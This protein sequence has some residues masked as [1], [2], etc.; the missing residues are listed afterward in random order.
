MVDIGYFLNHILL[1]FL[2]AAQPYEENLASCGYKKN[3]LLKAK[4]EKPKGNKK[5]ENKHHMAKS[6]Y[7]KTVETNI[8]K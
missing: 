6:S 1:L 8:G 2:E 7:S 4:C 5:T 3:K